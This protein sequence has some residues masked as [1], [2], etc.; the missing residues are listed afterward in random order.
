M[1][2]ASAILFVA[3]V[4]LAG[5]SPVSAQSGGTVTGCVRDATG[6]PAPRASITVQSKGLKLSTLAGSDGC[7]EFKN[8]PPSRYRVFARLQGFDI[9]TREKVN[10]TS[11]G[12]QRI[13]FEIHVSPI[14]DC[15]SAPTTLRGLWE[16]HADAVVHLRIT[17]HVQDLFAPRGFIA[18]TSDVLEILKQHPVGGPPDP[19]MAALHGLLKSRGEKESIRTRMTFLQNQSSAAPDPYDVGDEFVMFMR[20]RQDDQMFEAIT[21]P[22]TAPNDVPTVFVVRNGRVV[23]SP[24]A[25]ARYT[26]QPVAALLSDLRALA[27]TK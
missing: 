26:N 16:D 19:A 4:T 21:D 10:V 18:H 24:A 7:F 1:P 27:P 13:D 22:N 12:V 8:V 3:A 14:C 11:T 25:L 15:G 20:Y 6:Q 17:D 9:V 23:R 5:V 2:L